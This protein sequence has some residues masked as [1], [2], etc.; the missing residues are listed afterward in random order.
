MSSKRLPARLLLWGL[1][2]ALLA[3][4]VS[5]SFAEESDANAMQEM[6]IFIFGDVD[7]QGGVSAIWLR[8][9]PLPFPGRRLTE[10]MP[11]RYPSI[12]AQP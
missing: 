9:I 12:Q 7:M 11:I 3:I 1:L 8:T 2:L 10:P 6:S 5:E 4:P